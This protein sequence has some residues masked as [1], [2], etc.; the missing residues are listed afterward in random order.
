LTKW[1]YLCSQVN[2]NTIFVKN[3]FR[4]VLISRTF[5]HRTTYNLT[6]KR[7][8]MHSCT[9]CYTKLFILCAPSIYSTTVLNHELQPWYSTTNF[10][11]DAQPRYSTTILNHK[12][13]PRYSTT[14]L[15]HDTHPQHVISCHVLIKE[16][17]ERVVDIASKLQQMWALTETAAE[18]EYTDEES[19]FDVSYRD[20]NRAIGFLIEPTYHIQTLLYICRTFLQY[21]HL[22]LCTSS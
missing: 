4:S 10:N 21:E 16:A 15:S 9:L 20:K 6:N 22:F 14:I 17:N 3:Y 19:N 7:Y 18:N 2:T 5:F 12:L 11:H 1:Q 13:Q 8:L